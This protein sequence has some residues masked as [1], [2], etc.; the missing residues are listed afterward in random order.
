MDSVSASYDSIRGLVA[1]RWKR[2]ATG[3]EL[4]VTVPP[5]ATGRVYVPASN[6]QAVTEAGEG[7]AVIADKVDQSMQRKP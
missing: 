7:K 6:S 5:N 3:L 4:D 2:T 1:T